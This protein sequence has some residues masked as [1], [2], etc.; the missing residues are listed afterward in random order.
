MTN[1]AQPV[2]MRVTEEQ[3]EADLRKPLEELG[4]EI[5]ELFKFSDFP[6][7]INNLGDIRGHL[8]NVEDFANETYGRYFIDHYNPTLFLALA[9]MREGDEPH[10]GEWFVYSNP[11][12][13]KINF[14]EEGLYQL[15][16]AFSD[17][18]AF[19]D[20]GGNCNGHWPQNNVYFTK[21]SK[22]EIIAH[23]TK[24]KT[25]NK[26]IEGYKLIKPEYNAA[27]LKLVGITAWNPNPTW[28]FKEGSPE[29]DKLLAAG[30]LNLWFAPVYEQ[31][32]RYLTVTCDQ[33]EFKVKV[34]PEG[35]EF[36]SNL[37]PL[38]RIK[39]LV[40]IMRNAVSI[41]NWS[42]TFNTVNIGCKKNITLDSLQKLIDAHGKD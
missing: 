21:A 13:M 20:D 17:E 25:M 29:Y 16:G 30:V 11:D 31:E 9:A 4:Y 1:F 34:V 28:D 2:S 12:G 24:N 22:E 10:V 27:A 8:S 38:Q 39:D 26:K 23:F 7:L 36:E 40:N 6:I 32:D 14:R 19:I 3:F 5:K 33:G 18:G 15:K 42:T 35:F 37:V 41:G